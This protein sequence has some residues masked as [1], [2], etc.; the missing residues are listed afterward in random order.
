MPDN[1]FDQP[2]IPP[3]ASGPSGSS[4]SRPPRPAPPSAAIDALFPQLDVLEVI[5]QGGMGVVYKARQ[6]G[7][8]RVVALKV[9]PPDAASDAGFAER[10]SREARAMASLQHP[11]IV[12]VHDSGQMGDVYYLIMEY[13]DG[14]N[15]R[16]I[17]DGE[18]VPP[19]KALEIVSA[20]CD[21]LQYA[22]EEG[23][24]HR[25]IKP[26]NILIDQRG[27]IKITDF[28]L[29]KLLEGNARTFTLTAPQQIMG[30]MHYMAPEQVEQPLTVD[31]RADI[32]ALGVV[33]YE[34]LTGELPIGRFPNP[35]ERS[36]I[37][38][39]LDEIVLRALEKEPGRRYQHASDVRTDLDRLS[40]GATRG[41]APAAA[42]PSP[43][44]GFAAATAPQA[45]AVSAY[46]PRRPGDKSTG[47]GYLLWLLGLLGLCGMHRFYAGRWVTGIIWLLT[48]GCLFIG[49]LIDLFLLPGM[50]RIS[51]LEA[52]ILA[53]QYAASA[54]VASQAG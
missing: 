3:G 50:I 43:P 36:T 16:A 25:D 39:R 5:G 14:T 1:I 10:F 8:D 52:E 29:A 34:L 37:D 45:P 6:T 24:V 11:N 54:G 31:H 33:I 7:L 46:P 23:V 44:A 15:L 13:I 51:N 26:E 47:A 9:L 20:V 32:Y 38:H 30:T 17:M 12:V 19:A 41:H 21:A 18:R 22:H 35:S 4:G 53:R 28:G 27:R 49:Q 2:T 48:G 42:P 40:N